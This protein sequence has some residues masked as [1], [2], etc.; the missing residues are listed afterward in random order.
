MTDF[1]VIGGGIAGVSAAAHLAPHGSVVLLETESS[2][3]YHTTGRSAA[4]YIVNYGGAGSRPLALASKDFLENPPDFAADDPLLTPRGALWVATPEQLAA[5][6]A[7]AQAGKASGADSETLTPEEV[8]GLAPM[9][10][11]TMLGGGIFESDA[12]DVDVAGLHQ[13]FVRII[14]KHGGTIKPGAPVAGLSRS[15]NNWVIDTPDGSIETG[16]VVNA[17]GAWGDEVARLAGIPPVGLQPKRRTAFMVPGSE[18]FAATPMVVN[19]EH[20]YYFRPDGT[21]LLCSLAEE[22]PSDPTDPKPRMEDVA[23]AIERINDVTTLGIRTV[24]SQWTGLRTFAPD[25]DMVIGEEPDAKGFFW[26]VGLG[27]TGITTAPAFGALVASQVLHEGLPPHLE[28]AGVD[29]TITAP[30]RFR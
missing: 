13:A 5:L 28:A 15:G 14:R 4:I 11:P 24:N 30:D 23:L 1:V 12:K 8:M 19:V 29:P 7:I 18:D 26:L 10:K 27:G 3:A 16:A 6:D 21:Q 9:M 25:G 17:S 20:D 2:L 22:V